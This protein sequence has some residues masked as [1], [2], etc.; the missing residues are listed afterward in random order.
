MVFISTSEDAAEERRLWADFYEATARVLELM[1][2]EGTG[3]AVVPQIAAEH[4]AADRALARLKQLRG[5]P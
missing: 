1:R 4:A 5:I 2:S 3:E